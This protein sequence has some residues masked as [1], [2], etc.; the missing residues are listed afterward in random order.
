MNC[1]RCR[2]L[3]PANTA[4]C[5]YCGAPLT[6]PSARRWLLPAVFLTVGLVTA[7]LV[8]TFWQLGP[9]RAGARNA[10]LSDATLPPPPTAAAPSA[11]PSLATTTTTSTPL[12][13][14][15]A[16]L[17]GVTSSLPDEIVFQSNRDGDY[18][19]YIMALD[20]T[21]QRALTDNDV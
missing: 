17:S 20:G 1:P 12:A 13:A 9:G 18:D 16:P 15:P 8:Y 2:R 7:A 11:A 5:V 4:F 21:N 14:T 19:I 3:V 10:A 6:P